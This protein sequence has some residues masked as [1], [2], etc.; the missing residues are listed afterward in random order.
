MTL[1][2]ELSSIVGDAF[3]ANGFDRKFGQVRVSDRPDLCQFQ[4]NGALAVAKSE[5]RNPR[6]IGQLVLDRLVGHNSIEHVAL[7]G[8]GF[9]NFDLNDEFLGEKLKA[10]ASTES[11]GAYG[12]SNKEKIVIDYGGPNVAKP[13]HVGHLRSAI[14]GEALKGI[15][16][17][18]GHEVTGD[19]HLGDWG[20][21]MGQLISELA[22][23][24]PDLVYFDPAY[25]GPYPEEPP[26]T[27]KDLEELYPIA[28]AACKADNARAE[29]ARVATQELQTGRAGYRALW[30]HFVDLSIADMK[31]NYADL[32]VE[33]D[34]WKG[35]ADADPYIEE[36]VKD[37]EAKSLVELSDGAKII[38]VSRESDK[39]EVPPVILVNSKG[40][41]GYHATD[42]ATILDRK[43]NH[44][45]DR[46]LYVVDNRQ[47]LHFEQLYRVADAAGYFPEERLEHLGF[48]TMNG[49]DKKP[50]KTRE[51]GVLK[52]RDLIDLV[53]EKARERLASSGFS[54]DYTEEEMALIP[55]QIGVAA[56][57]FADLSNPRTT[58]YVFDLERFVAFEGKTG[59]YLLYAVVRVDAVLSKAAKE[60]LATVEGGLDFVFQKEEERR[61]ALT[62]LEFADAMR[63]SIDKRLPHILCEHAYTLAQN[64]SKFYAACR[65]SDEADRS[66][67]LTR[68]AL[69]I[70]V[71][72]QLSVILKAMAIPVPARM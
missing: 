31:N 2:D 54:D 50:F 59:P 7:A 44:D 8:P 15:L 68:I 51:G 33:F 41:V 20:L 72:R 1:T 57:K 48:G 19:I 35:E 29:Q 22:V 53:T 40:A 61:V 6:E 13:L 66:A 34:V 24:Q 3:E 37:L 70:A 28:S 39:K 36:M 62:L 42:I 47:A 9:L 18:A 52:L 10:V 14:I 45:P 58:D 25:T 11:L 71:K 49:P 5:G 17:L 60:D 32:S 12:A 64:F 4:C 46:I 65:I 30:R 21:Q 67:R 27:L 63:S 55:Q 23:R 56:L 26:I 69:S 43:K 38:R 16:R